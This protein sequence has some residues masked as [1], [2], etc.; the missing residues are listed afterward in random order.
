MLVH[1]MIINL[2]MLGTRM[3]HRIN[4]QVSHTKIVTKDDK[5]AK[6]R[7]MELTKQR[8][9]PSELNC[10][11]SKTLALKLCARVRDHLFDRTRYK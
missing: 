8:L 6:K 11:I 2:N 5:S 7:N 9:D 4:S 3:H 10:S 1:K